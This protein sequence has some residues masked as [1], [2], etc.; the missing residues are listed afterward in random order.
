MGRWF[1]DVRFASRLLRKQTGFTV[2]AGLALALGIGANTALFSL[3]DALLFRPM[4]F[5]DLDRIVA[6]GGVESRV[7]NQLREMSV[8][9]YLAFREQARTIRDLSAIDGWDVNLTGGGEP[10]RVRGVKVSAA[11]FRTLGVSPPMGRAFLDEEEQAGRNRVVLISNGLWQRRFGADPGILRKTIELNGEAHQVIGVV[12]DDRKHPAWAELWAPLV[13]STAQ[14][15]ADGN[16]YLLAIGRLKAGA[17]LPESSAEIAA[18]A[19]RMSTQY[20]ASHAGLGG[21][22]GLLREVVSGEE[23]PQFMY[24][25]MGATGFLLLLACSNVANLQFARV[26]ARGKEM[27]VRSAMGAG[28]FRLLRLLLVESVLVALAGAA[29]GVLFALWGVDLIKQGMPAAVEMRLPGWQRLG[30]DPRALLFTLGIGLAAGMFAGISSAWIGS[31]DDSQ[32]LLKEA[33]RGATAS[34]A[35]HRIRGAL[36]IV[37]IVLAIV[38]LAGAGLMIKGF[39]ALLEPASGMA[40]AQLLTMGLHLP[41]SRYADN[42]ALRTFTAGLETRLDNATALASSIPYGNSRSSSN[43]RM[44]HSAEPEP[45]NRPITQQDSVSSGYFRAM[46]IPI[47]QGRAIEQRDGADAGRVAVVN[48]AFLRRYLPEGNPLGKRFQIGNNPEVEA[49]WITIVGVSAD[50]RHRWSDRTIRP[51][52]YLPL[53]QS[54]RRSLTL[55]MRDANGDPLRLAGKVRAALRE[56]DPGQPVFEVKTFQ[57]LIDESVTPLRYMAS[58]MGVFG[59]IAL[60]LSTIGIYGVMAFT[61][62]E[63][64]HEIGIRMAL[65]AA[66]GEVVRQVVRRGLTLTGIGLVIGL[67]LAMA[68]TRLASGIIY[69]VTPWDLGALGAVS[70]LLLSAAGLACYIPARRA[71]RVDPM[72]ALRVE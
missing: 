18:I 14:R 50:V 19:E 67:A 37:Q 47:L 58:L 7:S 35:T 46:R 39:R 28:R 24:L 62:S 55:V 66:R 49:A 9:D 2:M 44:E 29:G 27:A 64:T 25:L 68:L 36:V 3:A 10:E 33:G 32:Q 56:I 71:A 38:L 23:T 59:G 52:A 53:A 21:R 69:G 22:T 4:L 63:R 72:N 1:S 57:R 20:P 51:L 16:F 13:F 40:P 6:V 60:V 43:F 34:G 65:G 48:A 41:E 42:A 61:V 45:G 54:P 26:S 11:F 12:P 70:L 30:V 31:R 15:A 5:P 8:P 17:T